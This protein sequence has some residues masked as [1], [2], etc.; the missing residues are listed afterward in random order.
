[1]GIFLVEHARGL[2]KIIGNFPDPK[3]HFEAGIIEKAGNIPHI[4][5]RTP[6][7]LKGNHIRN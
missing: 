3:P 5:C 1:M 6:L 7:G 2:G 4:D